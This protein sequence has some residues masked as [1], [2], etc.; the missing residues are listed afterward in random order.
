MFKYE[1]PPWGAKLICFAYLAIS[2]L[3]MIAFSTYESW[4]ANSP[5]ILKYIFVILSLTFLL[6]ALKPSN[7]QGWVYF[8]ADDRGLNFPTSFDEAKN[9]SSLNVTW[10]NVGIIKS[11][12]LYGNVRGIS[13][14]LNISQTDI[15]SHFGKVVLTNKLLGFNQKR[16]VF[17][18]ISYANNAFQN[19]S[20]VV[21]S[22]NEVKRSNI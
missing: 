3:M 6:P 2:C 5:I 18:V 12:I 22:L 16:G 4:A 14:E 20:N 11:E 19:V 10:K 15:D 8:S 21:D 9:K 7:W 13:I 17:F 1:T